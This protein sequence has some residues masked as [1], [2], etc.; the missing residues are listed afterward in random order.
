MDGRTDGYGLANGWAVAVMM[1]ARKHLS[2]WHSLNSLNC[3]PVMMMFISATEKPSASG[4]VRM[5]AHA[6]TRACTHEHM[7]TWGFPGSSGTSRTSRSAFLT[8]SC[9]TST[10]SSSRASSCV[11]AYAHECALLP[12]PAR[13]PARRICMNAC[14]H[15]AV[16]SC[17]QVGDACQ[18]K[19]RIRVSDTD[20]NEPDNQA[21][22]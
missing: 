13:P 10:P 21:L 2:S 14:I 17:V 4:A 11:F 12:A 3:D 20:A 7:H 5:H 15:A 1:Q 9:S 6:C 16:L 8:S 18:R 19:L 22:K